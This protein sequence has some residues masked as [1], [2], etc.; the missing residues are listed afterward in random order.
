MPITPSTGDIVECRFVS[1]LDEQVSYNVRHYLVSDLEGAGTTLD[2]FLEIMGQTFQAAVKNCMSDSARF[3]GLDARVLF[4]TKSIYVSDEDHAG[5]GTQTGDPLPTQTSGV[6]T[7]RSAQP[8]RSGRGRFYQPF[9][10]ESDNDANGKPGGGYTGN[11]AQLANLLDNEI[12]VSVGADGFNYI[13]V[14]WSRKDSV[15]YPI[16]QAVAR[17][18]WGTQRSRGSYGKPNIPPF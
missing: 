13:P 15:Y 17:A 1:Q 8:G 9:P 2:D 7:L 10:S 3:L 6:I 11:L 5:D 14:V 4:P 12:D 16:I 18:R